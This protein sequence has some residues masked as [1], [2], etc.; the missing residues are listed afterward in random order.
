MDVDDMNCDSL[1]EQAEKLSVSEVLTTESS[2][3]STSASERSS[4]LPGKSARNSKK[5]VPSLREEKKDGK[6]SPD[7]G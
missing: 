5:T 6:P 1:K 2:S 3:M 4:K 7:V